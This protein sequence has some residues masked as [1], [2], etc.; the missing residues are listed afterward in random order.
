M[1]LVICGGGI[2]GLSSAYYATKLLP[3]V[4]GNDF[5][6]TILERE[7]QVGGW[8][9][10]NKQDNGG[11]FE[12]GPHSFKFSG[13]HASIQERNTLSMLNE[14][15][16]NNDNI[17]SATSENIAAKNR[18]IY[19]NGQLHLLQTSLLGMFKPSM[20]NNIPL[21]LLGFR[22][23]FRKV[24]D[25][26]ETV[27]EILSAKFGTQLADI[28]GS[29]FCRGVFAADSKQLSME[30]AFPAM[31]KAFKPKNSP[32]PYRPEVV[33]VSQ[34]SSSLAQDDLVKRALNEEWKM[35]AWKGGMMDLSAQ[36]SDKILSSCD[37]IEV[38]TSTKISSIS[39]NLDGKMSISASCSDGSDVTITDANH[40]ISALPSYKLAEA[41]EEG[42]DDSADGKIT[43][44][45][46]R[47]LMKIDWVHVAVVHLEYEGNPEQVLPKPGFGHLVPAVEDSN[48][49]GVIYDSCAFPE[50]DRND[51]PT[52][53]LT[54]MVGGSWF[55]EVLGDLKD[56]TPD[57]IEQLTLESLSKQLNIHQEPV[58]VKSSLFKRC[59]PTY[60]KQH[61]TMIRMI[62][63]FV[64]S[65]FLPLSLVGAGYWGPGL[66]DCIYNSRAEVSRLFD[67]DCTETSQSNKVLD[68]IESRSL[69]GRMI[70]RSRS[71]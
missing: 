4:Y 19:T 35:W 33:N 34:L 29:S 64:R 5:K 37:N 18:L 10:S 26:A 36:I 31:W 9:L 27:H 60:K 6:I 8:M 25:D 28:I 61:V 49:L 59:I 30:A 38:F 41:L 56:A 1:N 24:P 53:R 68:M 40:V 17:L 13:K 43:A 67:E 50:H 7:K 2:S 65:R 69:I 55:T 63:D 66:N 62:E 47:M 52:T 32:T 20:L 46:S 57:K 39:R 54:C 3:K 23:L 22:S 21:I 58:Y 71:H 14:L 11:I 16:L 42:S 45:L 70:R 15:G 44:E 48:I 12:W 51:K